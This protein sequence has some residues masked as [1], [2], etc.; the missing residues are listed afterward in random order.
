M[1]HSLGGTTPDVAEDVFIAPSADVIGRVRI[2]SKSSLWFGLVARGDVD[3]I[4]IGE[5]T[6]IQDNCILH[7]RDGT[8]LKI[9]SRVTVG[10]GVNLHACHI[11]SE[12]LVGIG[13]TVLDGATV[14]K[15]SMVGAGSVVTPGTEVPPGALYMGTPASFS[16]NLDQE[17]V[18]MIKESAE[19]Y[20]E[21][22]R[23]YRSQYEKIR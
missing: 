6:N 13:S 15:H 4:E 14:S 19:D 9:G 20:V 3:R 1:I 18:D 5:Q 21:H 7:V 8:P 17:E 16:R 2:G 12:S 22:G 23:E 10:H 11:E